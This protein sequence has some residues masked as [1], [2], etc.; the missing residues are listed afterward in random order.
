MLGEGRP[1]TVGSL[2]TMNMFNMIGQ[3]IVVQENLYVAFEKLFLHDFYQHQ[4]RRH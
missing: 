4:Q 2:Q 1:D 3:V